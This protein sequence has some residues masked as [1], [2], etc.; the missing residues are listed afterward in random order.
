MALGTTC[1]LNAAC[2]YTEAVPGWVRLILQP[3]PDLLRLNAGGW[4]GVPLLQPQIS[5]CILAAC[6]LQSESS[7]RSRTAR[8]H[9]YTGD[10]YANGRYVRSRCMPVRVYACVGRACLGLG[11]GEQSPPVSPPPMSYTAKPAAPPCDHVA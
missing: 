7:R 3:L 10:R 8:T 1:V 4:G 5:G 2:A 9:P 11:V 6:R